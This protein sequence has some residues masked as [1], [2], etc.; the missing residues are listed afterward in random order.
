MGIGFGLI[1]AIFYGVLL[2]SAP[3]VHISSRV[4]SILREHDAIHPGDAIM[5]DYK[6]DSLA[7]YQGGSIRREGNDR[8]LEAT[9]WYEWP[10]WIVMTRRIWDATPPAVRDRLQVVSSV[11]GW[12]YAN[13]GRIVDVLVVK[14]RSP[15][16]G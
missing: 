8:F 7:F 13:R 5:I 14:K 3:F 15:L 6:E 11:R 16:G 10:G 9:P 4:A 2:P 12:W 1:V